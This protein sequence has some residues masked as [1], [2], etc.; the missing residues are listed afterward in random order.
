ME[1]N[2]V[3]IE[4]LDIGP[5]LP[6]PLRDGEV[7]GRSALADGGEPRHGLGLEI[8]RSLSVASGGVL[9]LSNRSTGPGAVARVDLPAVS[10]TMEE[11]AP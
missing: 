2:E 1:A 7:D 11:P 10:F 8:A 9:G 4:V 6:T 5:G 3:R